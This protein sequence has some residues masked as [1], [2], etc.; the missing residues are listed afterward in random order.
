[1]IHKN[2]FI[3]FLKGNNKSMSFMLLITALIFCLFDISFFRP[4]FIIVLLLISLFNIDINQIIAFFI[5]YILHFI[6]FDSSL[7]LNILLLYFPFLIIKLFFIKIFISG[8][9]IHK[10]LTN[11]FSYLIII[12]LL[13]IYSIYN[14]LCM[15]YKSNSDYI[16]L[17]QIL[18]M[19]SLICIF[20]MKDDIKFTEIALTFCYSLI[21]SN[22]I[23]FIAKDS[24]HITTY[25][26]DGYKQ[27]NGLSAHPNTMVEKVCFAISCLLVCKCY[28]KVDNYQ[29]FTIFIIL[30]TIGILTLS[31]MFLLAVSLE[32]I[33]FFIFIVIKE[34]KKSFLFLSSFSLCIVCLLLIFNNQV[35]ITIE[36]S[37]NFIIDIP[38]NINN[39]VININNPVI[40]INNPVI[41]Y[42][43]MNGEIQFDPGRL[44]LWYLYFIKIF[45]SYKTALFGYGYSSASIGQMGTHNS[46]INYIY[47]FGLIGFLIISLITIYIL[48]QSIFKNINFPKKPKDKILYILCFFILII[49]YYIVTLLN[50]NLALFTIPFIFFIVYFNGNLQ[51]ENWQYVFFAYNRLMISKCNICPRNCNLNRDETVGYCK[52]SSTL[53]VSKV[54]LHHFE[55]P[56]ISGTN[57]NCGS[58]AIFFSGCNLGC[59]YCQNF[60][61]SSKLMGKEITI[62]GLVDIFKQLENAGAYNINL[63]TPTHFTL[64][65]LRALKIYKP[66]IP[67]IWNTSGYEKPETIKLLDGYVDIFLT[68]FKYFDGEIARKYS[69]AEN[70]PEMCKQSILEMRKIVP[71]DIFENGLMKKGIII[72]H[73]C[74]PSFTK[75]SLNVLD[76][77]YNNLGNQTYLSLM[78]QYTPVHKAHE[79][80]EINRKLKPIEYKVLIAHLKKYGF[81]N[82]FL[83]ELS[84][85]SSAYTPD[86]QEQQFGFKF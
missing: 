50:N 23:Y 68:D 73:L 61:I 16:S 56:P 76:W 20:Y 64:Q 27:F 49:G 62:N 38:D 36:K 22:L 39:P 60:E 12:A 70:Y 14:C 5:I 79:F 78:S 25:F 34:K 85:A 84:S 2:F 33:L 42:K 37:K 67:V 55:E 83:Q 24:L 63:V 8:T 43:I 13:L 66:K 6:L 41:F 59:V 35:L 40:N 30:F 69:Y 10:K 3:E 53:V 77:I 15:G 71:N 65:I 58:G 54:M 1:M 82:V 46:F 21:F 48:Y 28:N 57:C 29:F 45:F 32:L 31:R 11:F 74:L 81:T 19:I 4:I 51:N 44:Y 86:F 47:K 18:T 80:S 52:A 26:I 9:I 72:R 7:L 75:D 17:Y